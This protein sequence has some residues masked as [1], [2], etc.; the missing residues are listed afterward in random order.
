MTIKELIKQVESLNKYIKV[1]HDD[2]S[3]IKIVNTYGKSFIQ[4]NE[5]TNDDCLM[6][7]NDDELNFND[8][9]E[10]YWRNFEGFGPRTVNKLLS[11]VQEYC[12]TSINERGLENDEEQYFK[13]NDC[14]VLVDGIYLLAKA[15]YGCHVFSLINLVANN[16]WLIK[17]LDIHNYFVD[18][19]FRFNNTE[20]DW[21]VRKQCLFG[22]IKYQRFSSLDKLI[23]A[24]DQHVKDLNN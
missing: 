12:D 23:E 13:D 10:T 16:I 17:K 11:L 21:Y 5:D 3:Y 4:S 15:S 9:D 19:P 8:I 18:K 22:N 14:Y 7:I 20:I 24:F 6:M 1:V 2:S